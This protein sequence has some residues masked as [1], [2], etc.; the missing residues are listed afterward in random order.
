MNTRTPS[1]SFKV[2]RVLCCCSALALSLHAQSQ[3]E[4]SDLSINGGIEDGKARL[5][6]EGLLGGKAFQQPLIFSAFLEDVV[7]INR[8]RISQNRQISHCRLAENVMT[9]D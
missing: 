9:K 4:L 6:I 5:T 3:S 7:D 2:L 1:Q 8:D